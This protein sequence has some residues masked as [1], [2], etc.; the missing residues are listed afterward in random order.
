MIV[1]NKSHG[2][3][4]ETVFDFKYVPNFQL[5]TEL[6]EYEKPEKPSSVEGRNLKAFL[7]AFGILSVICYLGLRMIF[8][9]F[10]VLW[11]WSS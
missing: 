4:S 11:K 1:E 8:V 10:Q 7:I 3:G 5:R 6:G 9:L 2:L